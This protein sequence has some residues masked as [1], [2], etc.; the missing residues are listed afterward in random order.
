M[1]LLLIN[2]SRTHVNRTGVESTTLANHSARKEFWFAAVIY[3]GLYFSVI[4]C[5]T[6]NCGYH[7]KE[8]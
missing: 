8:R 1:C 3:L 5:K 2:R 4:S 6:Q 7:T